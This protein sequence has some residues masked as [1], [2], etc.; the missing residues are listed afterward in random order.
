MPRHAY[1]HV[2]P[3][4]IAAGDKQQDSQH[5]RSCGMPAGLDG[6]QPATRTTSYKNRQDE[7]G[8]QKLS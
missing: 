2:A 8:L 5:E 6:R 4:S 7:L 3:D 1:M